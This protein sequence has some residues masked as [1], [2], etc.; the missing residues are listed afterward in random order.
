MNKIQRPKTKFITISKKKHLIFMICIL[1][2][3][4]SNSSFGL[5]EVGH[6]DFGEIEVV[7]NR[8]SNPFYFNQ[9]ELRASF[10][11]PSGRQNA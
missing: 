4:F 1:V 3:L 5:E 6:Y 10:I 11:A 2:A 7:N 9:I 8:Y